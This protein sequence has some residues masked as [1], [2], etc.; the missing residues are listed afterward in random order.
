M[1]HLGSKEGFPLL[2]HFCILIGL[3]W[4]L[5]VFLLSFFFCLSNIEGSLVGGIL[6]TG[7]LGGGM[8][9]WVVK[10][11]MRIKGY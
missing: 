10:G 6:W 9:V 1:P 2:V 5:L 11:I 3:H 7:K 4:F 8:A